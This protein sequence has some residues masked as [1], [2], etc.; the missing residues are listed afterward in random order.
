MG[1]GGALAARRGPRR[2]AGPLLALLAAGNGERGEN[3]RA[4][5]PWDGSHT[6]ECHIPGP[7]GSQFCATG[8]HAVDGAQR[9]AA[10]SRAC[11]RGTAVAARAGGGVGLARAGA[12]GGGGRG[13]GG[14]RARG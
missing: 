7:R 8:C 9:K 4:R 10:P 6:A 11:V 2:V 1:G 13:A 3:E 14:G 12:F 5:T